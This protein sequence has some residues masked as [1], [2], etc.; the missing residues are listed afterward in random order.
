MKIGTAKAS[1][2][3][4]GS[5]LIC[6]CSGHCWLMC[7]S[8]STRTLRS[9]SPKLLPRTFSLFYVFFQKIHVKCQKSVAILV[10]IHLKFLAQNNDLKGI[11]QVLFS[12]QLCVVNW[13]LNESSAFTCN[14]SFI[15][16]SKQMTQFQEN[17]CRNHLLYFSGNKYST[18]LASVAGCAASN[19]S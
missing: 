4:H 2:C 13:R 9:T 17:L 14:L 18:Q 5:D 12:F 10:N 1:G 3:S 8:L 15:D 19:S 16:A 6:R 11:S 7:S